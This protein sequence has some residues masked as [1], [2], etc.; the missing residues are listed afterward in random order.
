MPDFPISAAEWL[1]LLRNLCTQH[2]SG[3]LP[4]ALLGLLQCPE[5]FGFQQ[6]IPLLSK[7]TETSGF[8]F[9]VSKQNLGYES[10]HQ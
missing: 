9:Q 7:Q 5:E 10:C 8:N 6:C 3:V 4:P 1:F 2:F